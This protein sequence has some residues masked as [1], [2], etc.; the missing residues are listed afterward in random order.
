MSTDVSQFFADLDAGIFEQKLSDILS[1]VAGAVIDTSEHKAGAAGK[2]T[3][4]L[5]I[6]RIGS[7]YQVAVDHKLKFTMP[8][9]YGKRS[10]ENKKSTPMHVGKGGRLTFFPEDQSQLFTR[11]GEPTSDQSE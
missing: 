8:T 7:S 6:S 3:I 5:D 10:E 9:Q 2:V 11:Q 4:E 1:E